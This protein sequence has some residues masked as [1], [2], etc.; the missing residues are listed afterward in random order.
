MPCSL[1]TLALLGF[2]SGRLSAQPL[3]H[4]GF[5][6][7]EWRCIGPFRGCRVLAVSGVPDDRR[8]FYF[9]AVSKTTDAGTVWTPV[10]DG[11]P[12]ASSR[13]HCG[14]SF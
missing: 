11:Q 3:T 2:A 9:G 1:R 10:F 12:I 14:G 13:R 8:T 6:A 5:A 4:D 7:L